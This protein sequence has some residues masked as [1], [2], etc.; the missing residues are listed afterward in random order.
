M[1]WPISGCL[2][3]SV[4]VPSGAMRMK[5]LGTKSVPGA[6]AGLATWPKALAV[7]CK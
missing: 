1:P 6:L 7:D 5:A 3:I 2:E 4:T